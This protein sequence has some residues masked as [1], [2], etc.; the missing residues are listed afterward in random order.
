MAARS[1]IKSSI[2]TTRDLLVGRGIY[3]YF[4][5][6]SWFAKQPYVSLPHKQL[7]DYP[8]DAMNDFEG[9]RNVG[10]GKTEPTK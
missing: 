1:G 2:G 3:R 5:I 4:L 6:F 8:M 10:G 7:R 9:A